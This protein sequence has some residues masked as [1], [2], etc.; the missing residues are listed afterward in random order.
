MN[1]KELQSVCQQL[2]ATTNSMDVGILEMQTRMKTMQNWVGDARRTLAR[3]DAEV[4]SLQLN[5]SLE[6]EGVIIMDDV[7]VQPPPMPIT[8]KPFAG[9]GENFVGDIDAAIERAL[10]G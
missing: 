9:G 8:V 2:L 7:V 6:E 10:R 1:L 3:L 4:R 5:A